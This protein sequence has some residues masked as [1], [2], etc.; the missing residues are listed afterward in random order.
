MRA[1]PTNICLAAAAALTL[2]SGIAAAQ[3]PQEIKVEATRPVTTK[4]VGKSSSGVP[5]VEYS[6]SYGVSLAGLNLSTNS[7]AV[8]AERR[9]HEAAAAACKEISRQYPLLQNAP[10]EDCA[11]AASDKAM[12]KVHELVAAAEKSILK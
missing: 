6:V 12:V 5:I 4:L 7:G 8:E 10:G 1:D 11:K 2:L 9:V 3:T